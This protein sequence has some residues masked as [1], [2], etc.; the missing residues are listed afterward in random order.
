MSNMMA[1]PAGQYWIGDPGYVFPNHGPMKNKWNDLLVESNF[2][3]TPYVELD[4]GKIKVWAAFTVYGDGLYMGSDGKGFPVDAGLIGIVP[5]ETVET[6]GRIDNDL[7]Y[8]GLFIEFEEPF[9][10]ECRNGQ[11]NFGHYTID[12]GDV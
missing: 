6:L 9:Q 4:D 11:F 3:E 1:M 10:V 2:F 5:V 8:C 12:T 7:N